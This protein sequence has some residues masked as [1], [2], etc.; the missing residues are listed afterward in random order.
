MFLL[1]AYYV[2]SEP[3]M[4]Y[5]YQGFWQIP[6]RFFQFVVYALIGIFNLHGKY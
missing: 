6:H 3:E 2:A 5:L 1:I 4:D